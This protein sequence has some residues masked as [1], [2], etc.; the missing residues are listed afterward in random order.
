MTCDHCHG[1]MA[2]PAWIIERGFPRVTLHLCVSCMMGRPAANLLC[3]TV[4]GVPS[5]RRHRKKEK[6]AV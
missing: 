6:V 4:S 1:E 2:K 3:S 5:Q